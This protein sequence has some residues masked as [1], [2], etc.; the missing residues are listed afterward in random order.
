[1]E[2][3]GFVYIWYDRKRKMYYVG[4]HWG[5]IDDGYI[6][7]SNRMREAYRR[8]PKDFKRRI[9]SYVYTNRKDLYECEQRY[10]DFIDKEEFGKKYYN[11]CSVVKTHWSADEDSKLSVKEKIKKS[12]NTPEMKRFF[13]E[14]KMGD[15]NPMK[16]KEVSEKVA[17]KNTGR[18]APNKGIP[19][20]EEQK[21]KQSESMK[22]R[23]EEGLEV[24]NKGAKITGIILENMT[25]A[26]RKMSEE[27]TWYCNKETG[28]MIRINNDEIPPEG[29]VKGRIGYKQSDETKKKKSE[30]LKGRKQKIKFW[31]ITDGKQSKKIR[32]NSDIPYGWRRGR[33]L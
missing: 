33:T 15:K 30:S 22:K 26:N 28:D 12:H 20:S 7:S 16:R 18:I 13:S 6:C 29:F 10:F 19:C 23:Y 17:K 1:M 31:W 32:E 2:K 27:K 24:W 8:R 25:K 4:S 14:S 9:L 5:T 3:Y 21:I 11:L